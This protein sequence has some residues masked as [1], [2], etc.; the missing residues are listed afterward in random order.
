M[1]SPW[2]GQF[3]C[4]GAGPN[5]NQNHTPFC[6]LKKNIK[7]KISK[8]YWLSGHG[9]WGRRRCQQGLLGSDSLIGWILVTFRE[10]TWKGNH[11]FYLRQKTGSLVVYRIRLP[12]FQSSSVPTNCTSRQAPWP[13]SQVSSLTVRKVLLWRWDLRPCAKP[14][15]QCL[16]PSASAYRTLM[17]LWCLWDV[18]RMWAAGPGSCRTPNTQRASSKY[19]STAQGSVSRILSRGRLWVS[20]CESG[21]GRYPSL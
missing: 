17:G 7:G 4:W 3:T 18:R 12:G 16:A 10:M 6:L 8:A 9:G 14:L 1:D 15:R 21:D 11:N 20:T 13:L 5:D 19:L 2:S